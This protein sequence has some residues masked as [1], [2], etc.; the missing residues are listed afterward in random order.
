MS[1]AEIVFLERQTSLIA[2]ISSEIDH[3]NAARLRESIDAKLFYLRPKQLILDFSSVEFMDSSGLALILGRAEVAAAVG[4]TVRLVGMSER[5]KR[6]VSLAGL[7]RIK[8]L[9]ISASEGE[10]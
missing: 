2:K 8:N 10:V 5:Y 4:A 7:E 3:H 9:T 1:S 6:L